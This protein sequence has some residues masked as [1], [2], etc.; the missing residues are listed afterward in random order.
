MDSVPVLST[1]M[2]DVTLALQFGGGEAHDAGWAVHLVAGELIGY[3]YLEAVALSHITHEHSSTL[4]PTVDCKNVPY[5]RRS[6]F[7]G[8]FHRPTSLYEQFF[9]SSKSH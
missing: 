1:N 5:G 8:A 9:V 6:Q 4:D 7:Q 3:G 2:S